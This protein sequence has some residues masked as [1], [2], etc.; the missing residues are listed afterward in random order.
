MG[1]RSS[2]LSRCRTAHPARSPIRVYHELAVKDGRLAKAL[3]WV[4]MWKAEASDLAVG[5][6][7]IELPQDGTQSA[8][9]I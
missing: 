1:M 6:L 2:Q 5:V 4:V 8:A 7:A 9:G 3:P